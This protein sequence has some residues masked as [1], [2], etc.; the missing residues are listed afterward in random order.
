MTDLN[1]ED[2][3]L[4][5]NL[6]SESY[7]DERFS[8]GDWDTA[9]GR[10]QT[11]QYAI[12]LIKHLDIPKDFGG[13]IL[14]FG[15]ALGDA[16]PVYR[17][18]C[19]KAELWGL[20]HS[21]EAISQCQKEYGDMAKFIQGD[22]KDIPFFD[23]IIASH[24]LEHIQDDHEVVR[25]LLSC[26][27]DLYIIVPFR[28]T[29]LCSEHFHFYDEHYY[30]PVGKYTWKVF[31]NSPNTRTWSFFFENYLKNFLRPFLGR[32]RVQRW[33]VIMFHFSA[34]ENGIP[35]ARNVANGSPPG[36]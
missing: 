17:E 5:D 16:I 24:I 36:A 21:L 4:Q 32:K 34:R 13:S 31:P 15:C 10:L 29:P 26:C 12:A 14:D 19:P 25:K 7:W 9:G 33:K 28:E 35:T 8:T 23:K 20:D 2:D 18:A 27:R 11:R 1:D 6:N 22:Q 30:Q 3:D